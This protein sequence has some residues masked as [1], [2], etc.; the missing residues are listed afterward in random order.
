MVFVTSH[1]AHFYGQRPVIPGYEMVAKSK[2]ADEERLRDYASKLNGSGISLVVIS[3]D[4]ITYGKQ[5]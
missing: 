4:V 1:W 3:G 5:N 2:R